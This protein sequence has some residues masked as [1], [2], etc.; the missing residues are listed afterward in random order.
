MSFLSATKDIVTPE[1]RELFAFWHRLCDGRPW[2]LRAQLDIID[3]KPWLGQIAMLDYERDRDDYFYRVFGSEL[4]HEL[5]AE[6]TNRWVSD[7]EPA[8]AA[9][10]KRQYDKVRATGHPLVVCPESEELIRSRPFERLIVPLSRS[11]ESVDCF[12]S[13]TYLLRNGD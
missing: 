1:L 9:D 2:P 13:A 7:W 4:A 10:L 12:L 11:N 6:M 3:L 8:L 5:S